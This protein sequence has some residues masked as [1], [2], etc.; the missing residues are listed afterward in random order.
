MEVKILR[1][2]RKATSRIMN[3]SCLHKSRLRL[4]Q[5][6]GCDISWDAALKGRRV[7]DSSSRTKLKQKKYLFQCEKD[8]EQLWQEDVLV[9]QLQTEKNSR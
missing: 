2:M 3:D 8:V 5:G 4:V 7:W 6:T 9:D 1:E